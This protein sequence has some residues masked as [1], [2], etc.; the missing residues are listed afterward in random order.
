MAW[1]FTTEP[2]FQEKLDWMAEF[3][4]TEI[5]PLDLAFSSHLVYDKDHPVHEKVVRPLQDEV[6]GSP[7]LRT[8]PRLVRRPGGGAAR[9]VGGGV[10]KGSSRRRRGSRPAG[11]PGT[12]GARARSRT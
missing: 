5:E 10:W 3:V 9:P 7:D 4:Q 2:E 8:A 1:D 6:K 11:A 12:S